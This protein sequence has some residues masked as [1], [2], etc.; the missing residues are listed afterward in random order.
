MVVSLNEEKSNSGVL[1]WNCK[2]DCG[3]TFVARGSNLKSGKATHCGCSRP[4]ASN[5][6]DLSG[7]KYGKL[8]VIGVERRVGG[9]AY[10]NCVC[11][12]GGKCVVS[13]TDLRSGHT[14]S[15]GCL[16]KETRRKNASR[17]WLAN[18]DIPTDP[19]TYKNVQRAFFSMHHRCSSAYHDTMAYHDRG[20]TVCDE[21]KDF[22][23][24]L[25]WA[26]NNGFEQGLTLDRIDV[27]GNYSP[28]N[29]RWVTNKVQQNNKRNNVRITIGEETKTLSQWCEV[30]G[31]GKA[32]VRQR[33]KRGWPQERWFEAP[34]KNP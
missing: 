22:G 4:P 3:N 19:E 29:C 9:K 20:I 13:G 18:R 1:V 5:F 7:G 21:W 33:M 27:N 24:F 31:V 6:I 30:Y 15:C 34:R 12:C 8:T 14:R 32:T 17:N 10:W 23:N 11:D 26:I 16:L 28:N 2:C 25:S